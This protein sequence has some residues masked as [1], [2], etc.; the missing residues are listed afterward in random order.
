[1]AKVISQDGESVEAL[2]RKFNKKVQAEGIL[3]ELKKREFY[4]KPS[5]IRKRDLAMRRRKR[6][7]RY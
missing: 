7:T 4:E 6:P 2:I 3:N 1:M 5:I